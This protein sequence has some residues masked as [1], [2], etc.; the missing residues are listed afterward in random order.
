MKFHIFG[1]K[2]RKAPEPNER[3]CCGTESKWLAYEHADLMG[4][5]YCKRSAMYGGWP[6]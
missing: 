6:L 4:L 1:A 3:L 5:W 2:I